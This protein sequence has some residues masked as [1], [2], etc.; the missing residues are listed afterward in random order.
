[1]KGKV[2]IDL[3][4]MIKYVTDQAK[5]DYGVDDPDVQFMGLEFWTCNNSKRHQEAG[6]IT[7]PIDKFIVE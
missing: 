6:Y 7:I 4:A 5:E 2:T 3:E 1:M